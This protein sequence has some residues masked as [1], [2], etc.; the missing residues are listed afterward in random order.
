MGDTSLEFTVTVSDSNQGTLVAGEGGFTV[1]N[2]NDA[3]KIVGDVV[4]DVTGTLTFSDADKADTHTVTFDGLYAEDGETPL[5]V[6]TAK[7]PGKPVPVYN[8]EGVLVGTLALQ[9]TKGDGDEDVLSYTFTPD[10]GYADSLSKGGSEE[11]T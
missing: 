10:A 7:V 8:A 2:A 4:D 11:I 1:S 3:P 6:D 9:F 5:S